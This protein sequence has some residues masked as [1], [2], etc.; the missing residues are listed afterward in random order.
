[1][2]NYVINPEQTVGQFLPTVY[3]SKI[4][5]S[6]QAGVTRNE[7]NPHIDYEGEGKK[8]AGNENLTVEL[9]LTVKDVLGAGNISQWFSVGT[10][11]PT[12][13]TLKNYIRIHVIQTTTPE[14]T[15]TWS[16][17][18]AA[19]SRHG[20]EGSIDV[21]P[22]A[23]A[24]SFSLSNF[25][26]GKPIANQLTEFDGNGN[27]IKSMGLTINTN[28]SE[29]SPPFQ[30]PPNPESLAYFVWASFDIESLAESW[31]FDSNSILNDDEYDFPLVGKMNSD[32]VFR[33]SELVLDGFVFFEGEKTDAGLTKT[34]K[35]W[36]GPYHYGTMG[37]YTGY[38]GGESHD[39][40]ATRG[41]QPYL[42]R[43]TVTNSKIQDF[44][45]K[46]R[47]DKL[48]L[49]FS[50]LE[51][52]LLRAVN[53]NRRNIIKD[54]KFSYFTDIHLSRDQ[55]NNCR[56]FFGLDL[57]KLVR[58]NTPYS[59]LFV[60]ESTT[61][62]WWLKEALLRVRILSMK[63]YRKRVVG[64]SEVGTS[65]YYFPGDHKFEPT[66]KLKKFD[67]GLLRNQRSLP[68]LFTA[69]AN[70]GKTLGISRTVTLT[71]ESK[72]VSYDPS[73]ELIINAGE[74][75]NGNEYTFQGSGGASMDGASSI[76]QLSG[77]EDKTG[78]GIL[79]Y[80]GTDGRISEQTDGYY[81][82]MVELEIQD[83]IVDLLIEKRSE[84]MLELGG[85]KKYYNA[86]TQT[87]NKFATGSPQEA[88][89]NPTT[90]RF[91]QAFAISENGNNPP[92]Q[93]AEQYIDVL[94]M[95]TP[96]SVKQ[97]KGWVKM[98]NEFISPTSGNPQGCMVLI[99]LYENL[100]SFMDRA[101]GIQKEKPSKFPKVEDSVNATGQSSTTFQIDVESGGKPSAKIFKIDHTFSDYYDGN[102]PTD[103]GFDF[104]GADYTGFPRIPES[105]GIRMIGDTTFKHIIRKELL[106]I[107][108][109][110]NAHLDMSGFANITPDDRLQVTDFSYL[111]PAVVYSEGTSLPLVGH[112][113]LHMPHFDSRTFMNSMASSITAWTRATSF[114]STDSLQEKVADFLSYNY[115]LTAVPSP[116]PQTDFVDPGD[117]P[118]SDFS[119]TPNEDYTKGSNAQTGENRKAFNIFWD[120]ISNGVVSDGNRAGVQ[121]PEGS[122]QKSVDYYSP[123][124]PNGFYKAEPV[125]VINNLP[126]PVKALISHSS[127]GGQVPG[128]GGGSL[129]TAMSDFLDKEPFENAHLSP[130]A[131]ILFETIGEI[132][133]LDHYE[134]TKYGNN[135]EF[136]TGLP[137]WKTLNRAAYN[138][139][140]HKN[141]LCR[142]RPWE[143]G[144]LKIKRH[145]GSDLPTYDEYFILNT[146]GGGTEE[147]PRKPVLSPPNIKPKGPTT[148]RGPD[149]TT[150]STLDPTTSAEDIPGVVPTGPM[151]D[152]VTS[153]WDVDDIMSNLMVKPNLSKP[154]FDPG[155]PPAE[156]QGMT[157]PTTTKQPGRDVGLMKPGRGKGGGGYSGT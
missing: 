5:L 2:P 105:S 34:D 147:S 76:R 139:M 8:T 128:V 99:N 12:N 102:M 145:P 155:R 39:P 26:N 72:K 29:W 149:L 65:P 121:L 71:G 140:S 119:S 3:I 66:P 129:R 116:S 101:I 68:P 133:Y 11:G 73:E 96:V 78:G 123:T 9:V 98:L 85:L 67:N 86:G 80:S 88:Y 137:V 152:A 52:D 77:I 58:E 61:N 69:T 33:N 37:G 84:L 14:A 60:A 63:I 112:N 20:V 125:D 106:K 111:T 135:E 142:I 16:R 23:S 40:N 126:N 153:N 91:T 48:E 6:N 43:Q 156:V 94:K 79:Y 141:L 97:G 74:T 21:G 131:R 117:I 136:S 146:G 127:M 107:F 19:G 114:L 57:R 24:W 122:S 100:L 59:K 154:P 92:Y 87:G 62:P 109:S 134:K 51:N 118:V 103:T 56:F 75:W 47:L 30:L 150:T 1:M 13:L 28:E 95:F 17:A 124:N 44:R 53:N 38:M 108:T 90:N 27:A 25:D 55:D 22:G 81:Q 64:S 31:Q 46:E 42:F 144:T 18:M 148:A 115:N 15:Q 83:N 130:K 32:L 157:G 45:I 54:T 113:E 7:I 10:L 89:F 93:A 143:N 36:T 49:N 138:T 151:L 41:E 82:Y 35:L 70:L 120:L 110:E 132:Q 104:L 4:T 50:M